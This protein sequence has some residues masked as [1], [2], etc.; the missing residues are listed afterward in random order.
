MMAK[1][2]KE[3]KNMRRIFETGQWRKESPKTKD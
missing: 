2:G 3:G 1:T